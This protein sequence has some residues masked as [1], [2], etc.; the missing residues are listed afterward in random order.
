MDEAGPVRRPAEVDESG[1]NDLCCFT[2]RALNDLAQLIYRFTIL[3]EG[4]RDRLCLRGRHDYDH[5]DAAVEDPQHFFVSNI[6]I[7]LQ[8]LEERRQC[9]GVAVQ[10][11]SQIAL[12]YP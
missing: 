12:Q 8:P 1:N 6:A 2:S 11:C 9:P 7:L 5:A 10:T 4:S 3:A